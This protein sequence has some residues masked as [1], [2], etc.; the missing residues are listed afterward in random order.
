MLV[1]PNLRCETQ[2]RVNVPVKSRV[3]GQ[4]SCD[5]NSHLSQLISSSKRTFTRYGM[6]VAT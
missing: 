6:M 5:S 3:R 1:W 4:K 2:I